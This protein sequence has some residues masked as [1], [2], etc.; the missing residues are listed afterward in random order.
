M[1]ADLGWN[2]HLFS[3]YSLYSQYF[4][5]PKPELWQFTGEVISKKT[6]RNETVELDG[7]Q[8]HW[9][10]FENVNLKYEGRGPVLCNGCSF[11]GVVYLESKNL[12]ITQY[13]TIAEFL[14]KYPDSEISGFGTKDELGNLKP[15]PFEY[16]KKR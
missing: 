15:V 9:C 14:R 13:A 7:K 11:R 16:F 12:G 3:I 4:M 1:G 8:F 6:F 10:I 5:I 2:T